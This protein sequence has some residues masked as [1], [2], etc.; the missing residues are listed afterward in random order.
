MRVMM[1]K[2]KMIV[3]LLLFPFAGCGSNGDISLW[4]LQT[5]Q[6]EP[7][8][9]FIQP[10]GHQKFI[11]IMKDATGNEVSDA[12]FAWSVSDSDVAILEVDARDQGTALVSGIKTG[13]VEIK[14]ISNGISTTGALTVNDSASRP[15]EISRV[16]PE[17]GSVI[18]ER[19][20]DIGV[21]VSYHRCA[22]GNDTIDTIQ[23]FLDATEVTE[24]ASWSGTL[25]IPQTGVEIVHLPSSS[26]SMG[27]HT[28]EARINSKLKRS[29]IYSWS[30][31]INS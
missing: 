25:D 5:L 16:F 12:S 9:A 21:D 10:G 18:S 13:T 30:F 8:R 17:E 29:S 20:P 22:C 19:R 15:V 11:A 31:K 2:I 28:V 6:I 26:I 4:T 23:L 14:I 24:K 3:P 1:N 27:T 7:S